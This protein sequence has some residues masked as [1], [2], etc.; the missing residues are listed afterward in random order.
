MNETQIAEIW[1]NFVD[2]I[3]KKQLSI[4]AE[5]YIDLLADYGITDRVFSGAL[6]NDP[7]L[8]QAISYYL[9]IDSDDEDE[10][11]NDEDF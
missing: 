9:D 10:E 6:G 8:D 5:K 11:F 3:D 7:T 1:L 2:Y 4:V